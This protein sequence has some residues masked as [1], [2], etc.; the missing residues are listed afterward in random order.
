M[1]EIVV[2][3]GIMAAQVQALMLVV[4]DRKDDYYVS[5]LNSPTSNDVTVIFIKFNISKHNIILLF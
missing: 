4:H 2:Y 1:S 5:I 3:S